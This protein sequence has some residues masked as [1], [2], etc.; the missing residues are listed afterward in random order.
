MEVLFVD[1]GM[2]CPYINLVFKFTLPG[3]SILY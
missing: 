1:M 3:Y 2:S